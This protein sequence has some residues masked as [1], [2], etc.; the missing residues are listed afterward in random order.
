MKSY[1]KKKGRT[2][3]ETEEKEGIW[4]GRDRCADIYARKSRSTSGIGVGSGSWGD[5][6]KKN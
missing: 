1:R 3:E 6:H 2:W 5:D 4:K